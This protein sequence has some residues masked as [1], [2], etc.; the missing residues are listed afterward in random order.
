MPTLVSSVY[1]NV[2]VIMEHCV[3]TEEKLDTTRIYQSCGYVVRGEG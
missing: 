3:E 2:E 1:E